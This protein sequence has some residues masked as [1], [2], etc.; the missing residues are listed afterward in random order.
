[1]RDEHRGDGLVIGEQVALGDPEVGPERLVEVGELQDALA[2]PDL[3]LDRALAVH[4]LRSLVLA[5]ALVG[6]RA[7]AAVVRPLGE[8]DLTD[9]LRL[10]PDDVALADLW[11]LRDLFEGRRLALERAQ[12]GEQ[13]LDLRPGEA[14]ADVAYILES[15]ASP[16]REHER[17][18][19]P[20]AAA[21]PLR[22]AG[23]DERLAAVGLDLEPVARSAA[24]GVPRVG[25]LGHDPLEALLLCGLVEG[26]AVLEDL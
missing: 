19:R 4:V 16:D 18:E 7:Q 26:L 14:G 25:A 9:E 22:V 6:G 21:L 11:H 3:L 17:T 10:D 1:V 20:G 8:L 23:D 5:E 2:D 12:L 15:R 13:L 24:D